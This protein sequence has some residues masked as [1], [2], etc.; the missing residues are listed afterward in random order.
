M[1]RASSSAY[2]D[3]N[4]RRHVVLTLPSTSM[5]SWSLRI[6]IWVQAA[7]FPMPA[8]ACVRVGRNSRPGRDQVGH[9]SRGTLFVSLGGNGD[10][11]GG[12]LDASVLPTPDTGSS[13]D[14]RTRRDDHDGRRNENHDRGRCHRVHAGRDPSL[15][16]I[17]L[18]VWQ[19]HP[20]R[21]HTTL[22]ELGA[23]SRTSSGTGNLFTPRHPRL[24]PHRQPARRNAPRI[25]SSPSGGK[26]FGVSPIRNVDSRYRTTGDGISRDGTL[27]QFRPRPRARYCR[28]G[29]CR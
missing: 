7:L 25:V 14:G 13:S 5:T 22:G 21:V 2:F 12:R 29:R 8:S 18:Q 24:T 15:E 1:P 4:R 11:G 3:A 6:E 28:P 23:T 20:C 16:A 19:I 17:G 27:R 9:T 26:R 10:V